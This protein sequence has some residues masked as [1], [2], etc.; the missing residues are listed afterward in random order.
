MMDSDPTMSQKQ[1]VQ[2]DDGLGSTTSSSIQANIQTEQIPYCTCRDTRKIKNK[3]KCIDHCTKA[4]NQPL[5][6]PY[7]IK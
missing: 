5:D 2:G 3:I 4:F 6:S 1:V 7:K